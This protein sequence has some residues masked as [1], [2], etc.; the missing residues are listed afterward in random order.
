MRTQTNLHDYMNDLWTAHEVVGY[1]TI[2]SRRVMYGGDIQVTV[3]DPLGNAV[4]LDGKDL[5][6]QFVEIA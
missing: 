4:Y 5:F 6:N 2:V 3:S 1:G